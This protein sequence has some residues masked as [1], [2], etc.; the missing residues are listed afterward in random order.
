[1][2]KAWTGTETQ[3]VVE[4][5]LPGHFLP[6]G[7]CD[8][9]VCRSQAI[10]KEPRIRIFPVRRDSF[11][12]LPVRCRHCQPLDPALCVE[13]AHLAIIQGDGA[14]WTLRRAATQARG[15]R[16]ANGKC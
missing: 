12:L 4:D 15:E 8:S 2:F 13:E 11:D 9:L 7:R 6:Q 10:D 5:L 16:C 14:P 3:R 1:M